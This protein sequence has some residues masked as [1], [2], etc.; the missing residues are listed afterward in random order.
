[1]WSRAVAVRGEPLATVPKV[2]VVEGRDARPP[3]G[4]VWIL[5]GATS[6]ERYTSR[7]EQ[8]ALKSNSPPLDR[9]D[10][11]RAALIPI[12][13][14]QEW[15]QLA[16]DERRAI[17]EERSRHIATSLP[18]LPRIARR[19][20]HGRDLGEAFDFLTWFEYSPAHTSAFEELVGRLRST[21]EWTHVTREVDIRLRSDRI[22]P[23]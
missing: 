11:T 8:E 10:A 18:Y 2:A 12:K 15:W 22:D 13:K 23:L 3:A 14:S 4:G 20:H 9:A 19:L 6:N 5:R 1:M 16:Q 17:F 7:S 21:E